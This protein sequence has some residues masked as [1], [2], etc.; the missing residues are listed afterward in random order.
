[1]TVCWKRTGVGMGVMTCCRAKITC[2][3]LAK[4]LENITARNDVKLS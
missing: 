4:H 2:Y 1:M 3:L